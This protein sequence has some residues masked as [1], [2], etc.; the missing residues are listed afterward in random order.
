VSRVV[1]ANALAMCRVG[2]T[3]DAIFYAALQLLGVV[4]DGDSI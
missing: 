1:G 3:N 4:T 2:D